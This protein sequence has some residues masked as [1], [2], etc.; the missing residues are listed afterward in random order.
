LS[1][2]APIIVIDGARNAYAQSVQPLLDAGFPCVAASNV[3]A[4]LS[5]IAKG[6]PSLVFFDPESCEGES[7]L[8]CS[9]LKEALVGKDVP[10]CLVIRKKTPVEL[11]E[12]CY[13]GGADDSI[14]R[15]I[16]PS[17]V[18][19]RLSALNQDSS[20]PPVRMASSHR[21][22]LVGREPPQLKNLSSCLEQSG[23][24]VLRATALEVGR[25]GSLVATGAPALVILHRD[26]LG[27]HEQLRAA[28]GSQAS[29]VALCPADAKATNAPA[30]IKPL[31][32]GERVDAATVLGGINQHFSRTCAD[33]RAHER[34][35]F[36]CPVELREIGDP[37][38]Q[39]STC[40]SYDLSPG[41]LFV[42]TIV[43]PRVKSCVELRIHFSISEDILEG[44]GVV[45]WANRFQKRNGWSRPLGAG[46]QF[47]GMSPKRLGQLRA[48]CAESA[49]VT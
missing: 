27:F 33:L 47:L 24:H 39:W 28:V 32:S 15:P 48:I 2:E 1:K 34:V 29:L 7:R 17:H 14:M 25:V 13:L 26:A 11:I 4:A 19:Q 37:G 5:I 23:F 43:P 6:R 38:A 21:V 10:L 8:A 31:V 42:R 30:S 35:S 41:G 46:I 20:T 12:G 44:T 22:V 18:K 49:Q 9:R 3:T 45:C 16:G 36:F 40:Y